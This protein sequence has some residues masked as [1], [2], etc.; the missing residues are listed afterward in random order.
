MKKYKRVKR[1]LRYNEIFGIFED[2]RFNNFKQ[3]DVDKNFIFL[4]NITNCVSILK[5]VQG[6]LF[7][8]FQYQPYLHETF[9]KTPRNVKS[10]SE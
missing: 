6:E 2:F 7:I 8:N 10:K 1:E 4:N 9:N 5:E 3:E